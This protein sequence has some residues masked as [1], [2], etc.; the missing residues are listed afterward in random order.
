[1]Q[2]WDPTWRRAIRS[3]PLDLHGDGRRRS[4]RNNRNR[5]SER[6]AIAMHIQKVPIAIE[7]GEAIER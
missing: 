5:K 2:E 1:M 4:N 7:N 3:E 6:T